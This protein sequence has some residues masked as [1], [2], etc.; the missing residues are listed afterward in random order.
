[1]AIDQ[2]RQVWQDVLPNRRKDGETIQFLDLAIDQRPR[3]DYPLRRGQGRPSVRVQQQ[4]I[5]HQVHLEEMVE[6]NRRTDRSAGQARADQAKH[7][8]RQHHP[9]LRTPSAP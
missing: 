2:C 7:L 5:D 9:E 1:L 8:P 6:Q 4:L 3:R